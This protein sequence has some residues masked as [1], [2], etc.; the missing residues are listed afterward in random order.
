MAKVQYPEHPTWFEPPEQQGARRFSPRLH[1][2]AK[3]NAAGE[4]QHMAH[5]GLAKKRA[6][7]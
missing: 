5:H 3:K 4:L 1:R 2:T 6:L 7:D